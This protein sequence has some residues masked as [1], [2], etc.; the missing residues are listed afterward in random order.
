MVQTNTMV[1][2]AFSVNTGGGC[3]RSEAEIQVQ[4]LAVLAKSGGNK[5]NITPS[6]LLSSCI[7][8]ASLRDAFSEMGVRDAFSWLLR[9]IW[10]PFPLP[11][12]RGAWF[13]HMW[14]RTCRSLH[15]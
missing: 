6:L 12:C 8:S 5:K 3:S 9:Y 7:I 1:L 15:P 10:M 13:R 4:G 14:A 11:L 2:L